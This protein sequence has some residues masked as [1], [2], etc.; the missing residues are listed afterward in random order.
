MLLC[1]A[2]NAGD[3]QAAALTVDRKGDAKHKPCSESGNIHFVT[4]L[5][6]SRS[7]LSSSFFLLVLNRKWRFNVIT[8][9]ST[10][11]ALRLLKMLV[12][13]SMLLGLI[14]PAV[15]VAP[16]YASTSASAAWTGGTGTVVVSGTL[17]ARQGGAVTLT[18][19][20]SDG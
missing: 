18:V 5:I 7:F 2:C 16:A 11:R 3:C 9:P 1:Y 13:L 20:T 4:A 8:L 17:Y 12:V 6:L 15:Q 10:K 19:T 14:A